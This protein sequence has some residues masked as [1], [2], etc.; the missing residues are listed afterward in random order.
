MMLTTEQRG[1]GARQAYVDDHDSSDRSEKDVRASLTRREY[2]PGAK[3]PPTEKR[4]NDLP[5]SE[6]D[7]D[8]ARA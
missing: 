4:A 2:F 7:V 1:K 3:C 5:T 6:S 8:I